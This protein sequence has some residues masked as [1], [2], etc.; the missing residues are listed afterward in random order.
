MAASI[1]IGAPFFPLVAERL[2]LQPDLGRGNAGG[3]PN[4]VPFVNLVPELPEPEVS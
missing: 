4:V 2:A 1:Q 3:K